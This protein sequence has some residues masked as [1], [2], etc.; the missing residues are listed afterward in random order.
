MRNI[1]TRSLKTLNDLSGYLK[2][3]EKTNTL[4]T[5]KPVVNDSPAVHTLT[6]EVSGLLRSLRTK[7]VFEYNS[8][9][10]TIY[11]ALESFIEGSILAYLE[12]LNRVVPSYKKLPAV[13]IENHFDFSAQLIKNLTKAKYATKIKKESI[14][15]NLNSCIVD[16]NYKLNNHAYIDHSANFRHDAVVTILKH[17]GISDLTGKLLNCEL[18]SNFLKTKHQSSTAL[19]LRGEKVFFPLDELAQRRNDVA[20][21]VASEIVDRGYL[22]EFIEYVEAYVR[23]VNWVLQQELYDLL[24]KHAAVL[25]IDDIKKIYQKHIVCFGH[26]AG[27][28]SI[29]DVIIGKSAS[30]NPELKLSQVRDLQIKKTS[31]PTLN[32]TVP[33]DMCM[34]LDTGVDVKDNY[35][36]FLIDNKLSS[37]L[38]RI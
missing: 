34:A 21:G 2:V 3:I 20:H 17:I 9:I 27:T 35:T 16:I 12:I 13:L 4:A 11:G 5:Y 24:C 18:F 32:W 19:N 22:Q 1:L 25:R 30:S 10:V 33:T 26:P 38:T 29:G 36:F 6:A 15:I 37:L 28:L 8:V 14:I 31:Y 7:K 23:A